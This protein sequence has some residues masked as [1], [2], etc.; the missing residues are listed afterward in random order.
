MF[1]NLVLAGVGEI[2]EAMLRSTCWWAV[3][4]SL[5]F[6]REARICTILET[7]FWSQWRDSLRLG[8]NLQR[9]LHIWTKANKIYIYLSWWRIQLSVIVTSLNISVCHRSAVNF[10]YGLIHEQ[11]IIIYDVICPYEQYLQVKVESSS[12][13]IQSQRWRALV[14]ST[15]IISSISYLLHFHCH[16]SRTAAQR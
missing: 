2:L 6:V 5:K 15:S 8:K 11:N 7:Y 4:L 1:L 3:G 9:S 12:M 13:I 14:M 16:S 10:I